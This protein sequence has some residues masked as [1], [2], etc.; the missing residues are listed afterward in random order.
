LQKY[1]PDHM[2]SP[3]HPHG[4]TFKIWANPNRMRKSAKAQK[5]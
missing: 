1:Y 5:R 4:F 2:Y 3:F